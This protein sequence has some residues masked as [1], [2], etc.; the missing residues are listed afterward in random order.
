MADRSRALLWGSGHCA[1]HVLLR[2]LLICAL[3][4]LSIEIL[5][6]GWILY[7]SSCHVALLLPL[8]IATNACPY[9]FTIRC[10]SHVCTPDL[11]PDTENMLEIP[12]TMPIGASAEGASA[13]GDRSL[14]PRLGVAWLYRPS[15]WGIGSQGH[16]KGLLPVLCFLFNLVSVKATGGARDTQLVCIGN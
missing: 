5:K 7:C 16:L 2:M 4:K 12:V 6:H 14:N 1:A 15:L 13:E 10:C 9:I 8:C 11:T 3:T